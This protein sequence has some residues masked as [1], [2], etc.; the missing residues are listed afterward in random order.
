MVLEYFDGLHQLRLKKIF[1]FLIRGGVLEPE[2]TVEI[3]FRQKDIEKCIRRLD[4]GTKKLVEKLSSPSLTPEA[5]TALETELKDR[6]E[7]LIPLYHSVAVMF[8]DLHD[9]PGRMEE[10]N[11]ITVRKSFYFNLLFILIKIVLLL[12]ILQ[13]LSYYCLMSR[14][15]FIGLGNVWN[16]R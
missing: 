10:K 1:F 4:V 15:T 12:C 5:K 6:E 8:A 14:E 9:T 7:R 16:S 11:C 2:G 3:K 13:I